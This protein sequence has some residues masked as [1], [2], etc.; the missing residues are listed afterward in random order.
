MTAAETPCQSD[1][2]LWDCDR[3]MPNADIAGC[4]RAC[5]TACRRYT[6]CQ[7]YLADCDTNG[8]KVHGVVAGQYRPQPTRR[9]PGGRPPLYTV[10]AVC[11]RECVASDT[12]ARN[13]AKYYTYAGRERDGLCQG[14]HKQAKRA[15]EREAAS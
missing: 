10:C 7:A 2:A 8:I 9:D 14:C 12:K 11:G 13:P 1:P 15:G 3:R 6:A 4:I 5:R